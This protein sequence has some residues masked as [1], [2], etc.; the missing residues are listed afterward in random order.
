MS[1]GK[2]NDTPV[3]L[4]ALAAAAHE[5]KTPLTVIAHIAAA[6]ETD[7][8]HLTPI[9]QYR[10]LRRIRLSAERSL[11]LVQ[12]LTLGQRLSVDDL[13]AFGLEPLNALQ[14]C[15]EA[16]DELQPFAQAQFQRL[17]LHCTSRSRV[18]LV[19]GN[20]QLVHSILLN[21]LDNAIR[22]NPPE[23]SVRMNVQRHH[24]IVRLQVHDA[25]P[26]VTRKEWQRLAASVGNQL[27][28]LGA[29][30]GSSGLGLYIAG[31][32]AQALGGRLYL[33]RKPTGVCFCLDLLPSHQ[34]SLL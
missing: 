32:M 27:Q 4:Q 21:L 1:E 24:G 31:Q 3:Q 33:G 29:R 16:I 20:R 19:V 8:V 5:L 9:E 6:T 26:G 23:A 2:I 30:P 15:E 7:L 12:G 17:E 28:P 18:P 14:L 10:A 11:R 25:G 34:L 13:T 22:H